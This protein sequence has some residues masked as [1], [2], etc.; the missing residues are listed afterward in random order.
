MIPLNLDGS[1]HSHDDVQGNPQ[2][3]QTQQQQPQPEQKYQQSSY[4]YKPSPPQPTSQPSLEAVLLNQVSQKLEQLKTFMDQAIIEKLEACYQLSKSN[5]DMLGALAQQSKLTDPT[6]ANKL[7]EVMQHTKQEALKKEP[8][9]YGTA[10]A[11]EV[12]G[13]NSVPN[14]TDENNDVN[15]DRELEEKGI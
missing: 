10:A 13:W 7:Y 14:P 8:E 11:A 12:K 15:E 4:Y 2:Q 6:T 1:K 5:N 9:S 3:Q